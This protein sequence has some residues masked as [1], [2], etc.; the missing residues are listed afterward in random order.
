MNKFPLYTLSLLL[1]NWTHASQ[2]SL[3]DTSLQLP[4]TAELIR[5]LSLAD[6]N[7]RIV[8]IGVTLLGMT[9]GVIGTFMLLRKRSLMGDAISH[10]T[11][12]GI[13]IAFIVMVACGGSGK[14][15][16]GLLIGAFISGVVGMMLILFIRRVSRIK[17]DAALGIILST[18]FGAGVAILTIIQKMKTGHAAGLE[19]FIYGKTASMLT[20]DAQLIALSTLMILLACGLLFKEFAL[21]CFDE[22]YAAAQGWPVAKLDILMMLLVV[23][24]TVIGLQAVGL[25][26]VIALFI[27]P[28]AAA[29]FWSDNLLK[30]LVLSAVMGAASG[31]LGASLSAL[32]PRLP[33]GAIIVMMAATIFV[34]SMILGS[35]SGYAV[36]L[37]RYW[38]LNR[39]ID[40]QHLLRAIYELWE[41]KTA[42]TSSNNDMGITF[43]DLLQ[44]RSWSAARLKR[45]LQLAKRDGMVEEVYSGSYRLSNSGI[46]SAKRFVRNH[47]LWEMYLITHADIAPSRVDRDADHI[48]HVLGKEMVEK[49]EKLLESQG[50]PIPMPVSPHQLR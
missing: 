43:D 17:E 13:G 23:I 49:L 7:T 2:N 8:V 3:A 47:R 28:S 21:L 1:N 44:V 46:L 18:F 42:A 6:H 12:P 11:L 19:S 25:I 30:V 48:E 9:S 31:Y 32:L 16:P 34:I 15:L 40:R 24:V 14:Y 20:Q 37:H 26:L 27:I 39:G 38:K 10:A 35:K 29:R 5:V 45:S 33:A 22:S 50:Q 41:M 36:L 4:S